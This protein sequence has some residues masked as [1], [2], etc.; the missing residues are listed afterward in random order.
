[1][2]KIKAKTELR[3]ILRKKYRKGGVVHIHPSGTWRIE[4]KTRLTIKELDELGIQ[5]IHF[6]T[7]ISI[8]DSKITTIFNKI[9][10]H[11]NKPKINEAPDNATIR[12][13]KIKL[14]Q[15]TGVMDSQ[16]SQI[17]LLQ[18]AKKEDEELKKEYLNRLTHLGNNLRE[19]N[20]QNSCYKDLVTKL[21]SK[22][23]QLE[24]HRD[25][26]LDL[27]GGNKGL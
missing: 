12:D 22:V 7:N 17:R 20:E 3:G 19:V 15:L 27:L 1:M 8:P 21:R 5:L 18:A 23:E 11:Y 10:A 16:A 26:L 2:M 24:K 14:T 9:E 13:L 6:P 4:E 25:L